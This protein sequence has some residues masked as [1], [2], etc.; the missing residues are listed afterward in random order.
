R[1]PGSQASWDNGEIRARVA[2]HVVNRRCLFLY[3]AGIGCDRAIISLSQ[4]G[5]H[6][7]LDQTRIGRR[8]RVFVRLV[9]LDQQRPLLSEPADFGGSHRDFHV[10]EKWERAD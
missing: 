4:R 10:R 1:R 9:L 3:Y 5:W 6:L 8:S 7:F 2:S